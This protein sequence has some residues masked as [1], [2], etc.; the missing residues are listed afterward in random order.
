MTPNETEIN[1]IIRKAPGVC[2]GSALVGDR[3]LPVWILV[4]YRRAGTSDEDLK[5]TFCTSPLTQEELDAAWD[6]FEHNR[7]EIEREIDE[8]ERDDEVD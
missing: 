8:N 2:G 6:Y 1:T 5:T 4:S 3:R 7:D